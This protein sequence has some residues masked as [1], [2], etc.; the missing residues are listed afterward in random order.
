MKS[1]RCTDCAAEFAA[2][3]VPDDARGCPACGTDS[4]PCDIAQD[5]TLKINW[6]ELR[7]LTI[8]ASN[9]AQ[10]KCP[11]DAQRTLASILR[12][13]DGQRPAEFAALTL[14]QEIKELP[15]ELKKYGV[16]VDSIQFHQDGRRVFPPE[17]ESN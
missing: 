2:E 12:R 10:K 14:L 4:V 9:W 3:E 11:A 1:I 7:I 8:W 15:A 6:H 17:H 13:L 5:V 16:H